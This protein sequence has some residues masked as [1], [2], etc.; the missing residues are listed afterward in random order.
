MPDQKEAR[1]I[2]NEFDQYVIQF[3]AVGY[4]DGESDEWIPF[5][6]ARWMDR[7]ILKSTGGAIAFIEYYGFKEKEPN[8]W[9]LPEPKVSESKRRSASDKMVEEMSDI[10]G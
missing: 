10:G 5:K 3:L 2:L 9:T 1:I 7:A 6:T 4:I 8:I